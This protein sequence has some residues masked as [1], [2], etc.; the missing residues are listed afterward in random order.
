MS[1]FIDSL[2]DLEEPLPPAKGNDER[3]KY[4]CQKCGGT[5]K[6]QG[7]RVH[8]ARSDCFACRGRGYFLTSPEQRA[9]GKASRRN[10]Q[11][12]KVAA[13]Y[14]ANKPMMDYLHSVSSW[15]D[16]AA[17]M[18]GAVHQYA[19]L[20]DGQ[21][22]AVMRMWEKHEAREQERAKER[23]QA[24]KNAPTVD[25]SALVEV[26]NTARGNG[27]KWPRLRIQD[28]TLTLAGPDSRN[29]G[30][31]YVKEHGDYAG[32]VM[33]DG[34]WFKSGRSDVTEQLLEIANDPLAAV[35]LH[36][37]QTGTCSCC[38]RELTDPESV[39]RG[40]GPVCAERYGW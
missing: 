10:K 21:Q 22:A 9:K 20:T 31:L 13:F 39:E 33:P 2:R 14:E 3:V 15:N 24:A 32:K 18:I 6:Y 19:R 27:L 40:I 38:G 37:L 11:E 1:D 16:F 8:Q 35:K 36:G 17:Q 12:Q 7:P 4:P 5:G 30:A 23:E 26:L 25:L 29:A 28:L 34:K